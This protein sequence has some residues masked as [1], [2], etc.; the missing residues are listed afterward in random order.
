[1]TF[2]AIADGDTYGA[3]SSGSS[4]ALGAI[5]LASP[6]GAVAAAGAGAGLIIIDQSY[7]KPAQRAEFASK[8]KSC[9]FFKGEYDKHISENP[10]CKDESCD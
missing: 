9:N 2:Q 10:D 3:I 5:A 7:L 1:M 6:V 8:V 4:A